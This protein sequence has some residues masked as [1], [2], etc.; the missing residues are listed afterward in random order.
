[1]QSF[2]PSIQRG[3][4]TRAPG[5]SVVAVKNGHQVLSFSGGVGA[6]AAALGDA[7]P[8]FFRVARVRA[9]GFPHGDIINETNGRF[10]PLNH[11]S[12]DRR[13]KLK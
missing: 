3:A 13:W 2:K 8:C 7:V 6:P 12:C 10:G 9:G 4:V 1:M 11:Q 5:P